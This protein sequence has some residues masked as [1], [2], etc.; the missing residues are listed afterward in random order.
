MAKRSCSSELMAFDQQALAQY[1][2]KLLI[3]ASHAE[4]VVTRA[5]R[6]HLDRDEGLARQALETDETI[7][8]FE[9]QID[10]IALGLLAQAP[11]E[12]ELRQITCGMK[13][14]RELERVGDEAT[15]IARRAVELMA[16]PPLATPLDIAEMTFLANA[17][18]K[19]ALDAFVSGNTVLARGVIPRDKQVDEM[20]KTYQDNLNQN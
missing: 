10:R 19:D 13:I 14:A 1:K 16:L 4:G 11:G 12:F 2:E 18:L 7:D 17:M 5:V 15:T 3:M 8:Q 9:I 6:A 20:N